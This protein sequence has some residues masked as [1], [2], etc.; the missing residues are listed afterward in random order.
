MKCFVTGANGFIG[1]RLVERLSADRHE[2]FCLV[3]SPEKFIA[4]RCEHTHPVFGDLDNFGALLKGSSGCDVVFHLAAYAKPWSL[5]ANLPY[6]INV[7]GTI[8]LLEASLKNKVKKFIFTSSAAVFGPSADNQVIDENVIRDA[9]FF[10]DY[11][12][13]KAIAGKFALEYVKRGLPVVILNPSRVFGPGPVNESNSVTKII[14]LYQE[15]LWH[16]IPGNGTKIGNYVFIDDVVAGHLLAAIN[17]KA[18]ESY[19]LGGENLTFNRLFQVLSKITGKNRL[20]INIPVWLMIILA[21]IMEFQARFTGIP[22]LITS[23]LIRKYLNHWNLSSEKAIRQ[24]GYKITP[25]NEGVIKTL[26]WLNNISEVSY[27]KK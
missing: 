3:R 5:E 13:S 11:E 10:N 8:N 20:L 2:V 9:P 27:E 26:T 18:G 14:K 24:L 4:L 6:K 16:I 17:G 7:Q 22:P 19:I 25:F 21:A 23:P 1:S 12:S 15:G